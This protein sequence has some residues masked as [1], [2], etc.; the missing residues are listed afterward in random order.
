[1]PEVLQHALARGWGRVDTAA[2]LLAIFTQAIQMT[3]TSWVEK[4][5]RGVPVCCALMMSRCRAHR[6]CMPAIC[7]WHGTVPAVTALP[8]SSILHDSLSIDQRQ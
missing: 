5:R 7:S 3:R 8:V 2:S 6:A 1:M 4:V